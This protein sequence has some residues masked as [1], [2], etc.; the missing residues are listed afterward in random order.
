[1]SSGGAH[2]MGVAAAAGTPGTGAMRSL[3]GGSRK[4]PDLMDPTR[5][6]DGRR[7]LALFRPYRLRLAVVLVMIIASAGV[8]M[9][10]Q[11]LLRDVVDRGLIGRDA[12]VLGWATLG[13]IG[14]ALFSNATSVWQTY[15]SNVV[16]QRVM[17]D[18][19][20][21]V[22]RHLQKMSLAFFTR[23]RTGEVQSRIANDIGGL[24]AVVT[25]TATTIAANATTVIAALVAMCLLD[26]RLALF[27][28]VFVPPS[29]WATRRIGKLRR[30]ITVT[31]QKQLAD[32][33]ALVS[34]S[35]SVSGILLGKTMGRG[36]DLA[37]RFTAESRTIAETEV[38]SRM[39]GRWMMG[40]IQ[41]IF[42]VQPAVIYWLAGQS[43]VG[44]VAIG[45]VVAFTTLQTRLLFPIN[46][47]LGVQAD[48]EAS[49]ALFDRIFEYLDLPIDIV[50]AEHP[51]RLRADEVL[52]EVRLTG[53]SFRYS[54]A[55]LPDGTQ[56][57]PWTLR[58]ITLEI[59]AGTRT[60]VVG[61]TGSGKTTL[62]YLVARL[63]DPQEG[64]VSIDG[65][66]IRELSLASLAA[67]V[68]VVSQETYLFHASVREN[69][70]FARPEASDAEIEAAA[71]TARI[72]EL[73]V[74]L[75]DGYDTVVGERGYR[76]SGG[77][78]QR[79]AIARTVLRNPPVLV[80]DEAT[81]AL[82]T[83]TEFA[84]QGELE[85]L[86][87]GRTT[88]TIAHRLS[89]VRD[90]DQIVVLSE[91]RIVERGTHEELMERGGHY[92]ALVSRDV[93]EEPV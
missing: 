27:S 7:I 2:G 49:L 25:T 14:V 46:S 18:L 78:R 77:E 32:L 29:V 23:T 60:A 73:I 50:E 24:D 51:V 84:I 12:G 61:E 57:P 22:Y 17:H 79:M 9:L 30:S 70:R 59:P 74:S 67:T 93:T 5:R 91:G 90:A 85:R 63:Y 41:F 68:G 55:V 47:L 89:T 37:E 33:S 10:N 13:M 3:R 52:G 36:D 45:T 71:Q 21:A 58:D 88:I 53:V 48:I 86:A 80:L 54:A 76:F 19:R 42:A 82:D 62:G 43:F 16:G 72:H 40:T 66:D 69:L 1:M 26:V 6:R 4:P 15:L 92:A 39:T 20:A 87:E 75:P 44:H 81:S 8:S 28:L 64:T 56:E 11:F 31:Q 83:Q 65:V 34:E 38:R 35:L